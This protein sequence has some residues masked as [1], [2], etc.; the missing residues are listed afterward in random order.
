MIKTID[1]K[2][3]VFTYGEYTLY[4]KEI[5]L[6]SNKKRIIHFFSKDKPEDGETVELPEGYEVKTNKK[7][8]VPY[9]SRKK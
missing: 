4:R 2:D 6:Q 8:G 7:T 9:I 3:G 5:M 1:Q